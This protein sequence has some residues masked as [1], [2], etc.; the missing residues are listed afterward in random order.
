MRE[1]DVVLGDLSGVDSLGVLLN[2]PSNFSGSDYDQGFSLC[3]VSSSHFRVKQVDGSIKGGRSEL[4]VESVVAEL[5][6]VGA[7]YAIGLH[8]GGVS[9][10]DLN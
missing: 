1:F 7:D 3:L 8:L 5:G 4:L 9:F 6:L 2:I 10:E